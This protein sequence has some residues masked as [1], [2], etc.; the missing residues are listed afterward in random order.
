[1]AEFSLLLAMIG[2]AGLTIVIIN[3]IDRIEDKIDETKELVI[4]ALIK[5]NEMN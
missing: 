4:Q 3:K 5:I 1:M 2:I